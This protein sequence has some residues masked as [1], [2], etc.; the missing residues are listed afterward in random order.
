MDSR[1]QQATILDELNKTGPMTILDLKI[2]S[3]F[4]GKRAQIARQ[5]AASLALVLSL[6]A[7][8]S[9]DPP[10]GQVGHVEGFSG[11]IAGD[12]P[13]SVTVGRDILSAGGTAADAAAAMGFTLAVTQPSTAG[14][15]GGGICLI[16]DRNRYQ[17]VALD[18][19]AT[20]PSSPATSATRANAVPGTVRGLAAMHARFGRL[21][22]SQVI[23]P[24]Q[25]L[26]RF[27]Y[28][29]SRAFARDLALVA[30][31]LLEDP[32]SRKAFARPDGNPIQEGDLVKQ[33]DLAA[34]LARIRGGGA[35][36]FYRGVLARQL[37]EAANAVGGSLSFDDLKNYRPQWRE[38]IAVPVSPNTMYFAPPPAG[39]G[40]VE[41]AIWRMLTVDDR[42]ADAPESERPHLLAE[43]AMIA[44]AERSSWIQPDGSIN[45][46]F[47]TV[48]GD[49]E[50]RRRYA[51]YDSAR[52]TSPASLAIPARPVLENPAASSFVAVDKEGGAVA[53]N[54]SM[55][56]LFGTG[57][58]ATDT[59][60]LL[61]ARPG[62][63]GR[64]PMSLG[65]MM[66]INTNT[67][68]F[69]YASAATGG[70]AAAT[71]QVA[72]SLRTL[73]GGE[74]LRDA[75]DA[76][77][78]HHAGNPD[79][80][81]YETGDSPARVETLRQRGHKTQP[82]ALIGRVNAAWCP[83]G[84][85]SDPETCQTTSDARGFGLAIGAR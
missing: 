55:N 21:Q 50:A 85:P 43:A 40:V 68:N 29:A 81:F 78:V 66:M 31:P 57:R 1:R 62:D 25:G 42:Y 20:A 34:T 12:E 18:F 19:L 49:A 28:T 26:S 72:V 75:V 23:S 65:P 5:S 84:L 2:S 14:L 53:C 32:E 71:A 11:L 4:N 8:G 44:F 37:V 56:N 10:V 64:G 27:G 48:I 41:A 58:I 79:V 80:T 30:G 39:A 60:I 69:Y 76:K 3:M 67:Q 16:H 17:T 83:E 47:Q 13:L 52:H 9:S 15:G 36:E 59:G 7:C 22:W 6:A 70:S 54:F 63:R 74:T 77:R 45:T 51:S 24:A 73:V 61:A 82:V 33:I 35:G 46:T 38:A